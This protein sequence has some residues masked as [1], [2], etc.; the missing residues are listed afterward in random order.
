MVDDT[1]IPNLDLTAKIKPV[2]FTEK[3]IHGCPAQPAAKTNSTLQGQDKIRPQLS[4][5]DKPSKGSC[6]GWEPIH[7]PHLP[8]PMDDVL[9]EAGVDEAVHFRQLRDVPQGQGCIFRERR[10]E[11]LQLM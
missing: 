9:R 8:F 5:R 1:G 6:P 4:S 7:G 3:E 10:H 2:S 11:G